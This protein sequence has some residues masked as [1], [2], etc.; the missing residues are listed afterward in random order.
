[1]SLHGA[2][3]S[4]RGFDLRLSLGLTESECARLLDFDA[5]SDQLEVEFNV[6]DWAPD[7]QQL[8]Q[9]TCKI[10]PNDWDPEQSQA[11]RVFTDGSHVDGFATWSFVIVACQDERL[12]FVGFQSGSIP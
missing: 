1:M 4:A 2:L 9:E 7:V 8:F 12:A 3:S 10:A 5:V 6:V 11:V